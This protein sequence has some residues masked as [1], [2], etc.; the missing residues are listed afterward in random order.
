MN[1]RIEHCIVMFDIWNLNLVVKY[2][3]LC[4]DGIQPITKLG[5]S[6]NVHYY[7]FAD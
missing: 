5:L 3:H 2:M 7:F 6:R 1:T 4:M